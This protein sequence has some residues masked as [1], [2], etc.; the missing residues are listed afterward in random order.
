MLP[1][2][3]DA[4]IGITHFHA[5]LLLLALMAVMPLL[6]AQP[7][8]AGPGAIVI[9]GAVANSL[10]RDPVPFAAVTVRSAEVSVESAIPAANGL[11]SARANEKGEFLLKLLPGRYLITADKPGW[12]KNGRS[13]KQID[14]SSDGAHPQSL[15]LEL[16]PP[17]AVSGTVVDQFNNP[18][19]GALVLAIRREC[20]LGEVRYIIEQS[21]KTDDRGGYRLYKLSP[22]RKLLY[23]SAPLNPNNPQSALVGSYWPGVSDVRMA[24]AIDLHGGE[25]LGGYHFQVV[26]QPEKTG[27][28]VVRSSGVVDLAVS[29]LHASSAPY[30]SLGLEVFSGQVSAERSATF[31]GVPR[32]EYWVIG[33]SLRG[34]PEGAPLAAVERVSLQE[35]SGDGARDVAEVVLRPVRFGV[36]R[37]HLRYGGA[38]ERLSS[39]QVIAVGSSVLSFATGSAFMGE[40]AGEDGRFSFGHVAPGSYRL[41]VLG[42]AREFFV[43]DVVVNGTSV[44]SGAYV[45]HEIGSDTNAEII[46]ERG[47]A[48]IEV[49]LP[50]GADRDPEPVSISL[51]REGELVAAAN[52]YGDGSMLVR[53]DNLRPGTYTVVVAPPGLGCPDRTAIEQGLRVQLEA[54]QTKRIQ[55]DARQ[56][57]GSRGSSGIN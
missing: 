11:R 8:D 57:A 21:A 36:L 16:T 42:L 54:G 12:F 48:S 27:K 3:A 20:L 7:G 34:E 41:A 32:G 53:V 56:L 52:N 29:L 40:R 17:T 37:G 24:A 10:T 50:G 45:Q 46:L 4:M 47:A 22:G 13:A 44:G 1:A 31:S 19:E 30:E 38:G 33:R 18:L 43:R 49:E 9:A 2:Y 23:A 25:D 39:L 35:A 5:Y 15:L 6:P 14:V 51:Y 28:I 55:T 26:T